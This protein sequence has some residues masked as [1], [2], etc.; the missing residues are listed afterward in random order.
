MLPV[1]LSVCVHACMYVTT[2]QQIDR[3]FNKYG[4]E[5]DH[6]HSIYIYILRD[7]LFLSQQLQIWQE[8]EILI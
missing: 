7:T 4:M 5:T 1:C 2:S 6:K 8:P 3:F